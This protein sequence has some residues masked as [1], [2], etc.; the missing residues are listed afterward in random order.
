MDKILDRPLLIVMA[1]CILLS[2]SLACS[3]SGDETSDA[4]T[5]AALDSGQS[6]GAAGD[7]DSDADS[8]ADTEADAGMDAG[9]DANA[10]GAYQWHT[11]YGTGNYDFGSDVATDENGNLYVLGSSFANWLGPD[12]QA[13]LHPLS[14]SDD[15]VVMKLTRDGAYQW[16]TFYGSDD[17][18]YPYGPDIPGSD[19]ARGMT[20]DRDGNIYVIGSSYQGWTGPDSQ[21]PL[22]AFCDERDFF[23]LKL[24][25]D[26]VYQWHTFYGSCEGSRAFS[27]AAGQDGNLFITGSSGPWTGP[28]GQAPLHDTNISS[29]LFVLN[30]THDGAYVWHT[31]Y[32]DDISNDGTDIQVDEHGNVV[33][34]GRSELGWTGPEGQEPLNDHSGY[35][36][37]VVL[38]LGKDGA[39][40]WHTFFGSSDYDSGNALALD[41]DGNIYVTGSSSVGWVG[42]DGQEPRHQLKEIPSFTMRISGNGDYVWHTFYG[43][44]AIALGRDGDLYIAGDSH[45]D[46]NGPASQAPLVNLTQGSW[47]IHVIKLSDDGAYQWHTFYGCSV[48]FSGGSDDYGG[49]I[50]LDDRGGMYIGGMSDHTWNGPDGQSPLHAHSEQRSL[51]YNIEDYDMTILKL[52]Q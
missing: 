34:V 33:V 2:T 26:G 17:D 12:G 30:L 42:P 35:Y 23:L 29:A 39:Y 38:K 46:W 16:H 31:Y 24:D 7:A 4:G 15:I 14:G 22:H 36:D 41:R 21:P 43:G 48:D 49:S 51:G 8:D 10:S 20:L 25:R 32:G 18:T 19:F 3:R 28:D 47:D 9:R 6:D 50:A 45:S 44:S 1:L 40:Q 13:P 37:L 11:F 27:I 52:T 5:D